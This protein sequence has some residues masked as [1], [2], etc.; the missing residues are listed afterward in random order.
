M[1]TF[2]VVI[3]IPEPIAERLRSERE[4]LGD[5]EARLIPPHITIVG[6]VSIDPDA[7][8][9]VEDH[10]ESA[11][12]GC[13][14]FRIELRGTGTFRPVS[15]VVFVAVVEGMDGCSDLER[16]VRSGPLE[17][18]LRF[19]YHP[20]VTVALDL[21]DAKLVQALESLSGFV[22]SFTVEAIRLYELDDTGWTPKRTF[23]LS[24]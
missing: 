11:V 24:G 10:I 2:G 3:D 18:D 5:P 22:D 14:P 7:M 1:K 8:S 9:A 17:V 6:P 12:E 23:A 20:H 4:A 21:D 19:P 16:R 13:A 15:A